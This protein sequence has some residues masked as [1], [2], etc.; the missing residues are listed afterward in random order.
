MTLGNRP[1]DGIVSAAQRD[2]THGPWR[3]TTVDQ[4]GREKGLPQ[5]GHAEAARLRLHNDNVM[6]I[7]TD[8]SP[9]SWACASMIAV[10]DDDCIEAATAD[11]VLYQQSAAHP[12][13]IAK[14]HRSFE[15]A[16]PWWDRDAVLDLELGH[17]APRRR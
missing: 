13:P 5:K 6:P 4:L 7:K 15:I 12:V 17:A 2:C 16:S 10:H 1:E 11:E 14:H 3:E 8:A 9:L